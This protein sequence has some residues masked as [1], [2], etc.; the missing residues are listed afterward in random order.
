MDEKNLNKEVVEETAEVIEEVVYPE[1]D[2][3]TSETNSVENANE[4]EKCE[5][6]CCKDD[7]KEKCACEPK[8][9]VDLFVTKT[10]AALM[11]V[12]T[13]L[14][15]CGLAFMLKADYNN[16]LN[17]VD[18]KLNYI[19]N[20][21]GQ[22]DNIV[23]EMQ[24]E[25]ETQEMVFNN[26][27]NAIV[28]ELVKIENGL[29]MVYGEVATEAEEQKVFDNSPFLGIGFNQE[30][31]VN[32]EDFG[33]I[34]DY[35]YPDSPAEL[36]GMVAGDRLIGVDNTPICTFDELGGIISEK[37]PGDQLVVNYIHQNEKGIHYKA[38]MVKLDARGNFELD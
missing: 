4:A 32:N 2:N 35:V 6:E 10:E 1:C 17:V 38:V 5:C 9:A 36:A 25:N 12:V 15:V 21:I 37:Q 29:V 34:V 30:N 23:E 3:T 11:F 24:K 33:L 19:Y 31:D 14:I 28:N 26:C 22:V 18:T 13:I 16:K 8:K 20:R 7:G 27:M